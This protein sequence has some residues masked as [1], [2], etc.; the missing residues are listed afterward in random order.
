MNTSMTQQPDTT[1]HVVT[2][3]ANQPNY[4]GDVGF[5]SS[6][7]KGAAAKV[8]ENRADCRSVAASEARRLAGIFLGQDDN[9]APTIFHAPDGLGAYVKKQHPNMKGSDEENV[10]G[11]VV[12][13]LSGIVLAVLGH[14]KYVEDE[15]L[16]SETV[17]RYWAEVFAGIPQKS[18]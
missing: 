17:L 14:R 1:F 2:D 15:E 18:S 7:L 5:V 6:L 16:N 13:A 9:F 3:K 12:T 4:L 8:L 10:A 11:L